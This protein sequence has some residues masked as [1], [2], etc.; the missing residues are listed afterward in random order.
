[1][2]PQA[3][4]EVILTLEKL[5]PPPVIEE[6]EEPFIPPELPEPPKVKTLAANIPLPTPDDQLDEQDA[7]INEMDS[8]VKA[9][10]IAFDDQD[11]LDMESPFIGDEINTDIPAIFAEPEMPKAEDFVIAE[12]E[13]IPVNM[14]DVSKLIGYPQMARDAGIEGTVIVRVLVDKRGKYRDH[15]LI[16][17]AHVILDRAVQKEL[18]KLQFTPAIQGG[19]PIP[20]WVNIPFRFSLMQ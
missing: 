11:G 4:H 7:T 14:S 8:L 1:L 5:D 17:S 6:K 10:N 3:N 15:K 16:N 12:E 20:F 2:L 9:P 19:K 18:D 13:P